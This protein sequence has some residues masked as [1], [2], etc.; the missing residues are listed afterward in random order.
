LRQSRFYPGFPHVSDRKTL[1]VPNIERLSQA[2]KATEPQQITHTLSFLHLVSPH[3][4]PDL[5]IPTS[6]RLRTTAAQE[7]MLPTDAGT[8]PALD[9]EA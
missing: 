9:I 8:D 3:L 6:S 2:E 5:A 4:Q 7:T 1:A